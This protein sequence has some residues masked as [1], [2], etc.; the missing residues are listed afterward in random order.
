MIIEGCDLMKSRVN[1]AYRL[2]V[3]KELV[4]HISMNIGLTEDDLKIAKSLRGKSANSEWHYENTGLQRDVFER[5][6][7]RMND[8][9]LSEFI[10]LAEIGLCKINEQEMNQK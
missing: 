5:R 8:V 7:K 6:L 3:S 2:P 4:E 1:E 9:I 10:R